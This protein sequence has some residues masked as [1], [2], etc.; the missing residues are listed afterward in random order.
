MTGVTGTER[1]PVLRVLRAVAY[2]ALPAELVLLTLLLGGVRIPGGVW[3]GAELVTAGLLAAEAVVWVRLRR[4]GLSRREALAEL[5]PERVLRLIG[6]ELRLMAS[7]G[8]WVAR[9]PHGTGGAAGVFPHARDQAAL[10]YGFAFVCLVETVG[11]SWLLAGWPVVHAVVLVL[12]VYT[13]LFVLGLHAAAVT[14]PHVLADGRLR[15][16]QAAHVDVAVPLER[17]AAVRRENRFTHEKADGELNLAVGSQ[18]SVTL[19]LSGPVDVVGLL[20]RVRPVTTV[21]LHADDPKALYEAVR[22]AV[23]VTRARTAPS[24]GQDPLPTA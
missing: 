12:D 21:R 2:A 24:P 9:R 14:R 5:V 22:D 16:R 6:H 23:A 17:I 11:M 1:G 10:M 15:V 8:R 4:R 19:E 20:G 7:L 13:V 3:V 18:T